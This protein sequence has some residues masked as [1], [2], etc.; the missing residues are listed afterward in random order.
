MQWQGF[1]RLAE[2]NVHIQSA[3]HSQSFDSLRNYRR[4]HK[5][6]V[7]SVFWCDYK[8]YDHAGFFEAN[9]N[10]VSWSFHFVVIIVHFVHENIFRF[11]Q[12]ASKW[13][14]VC[15]GTLGKQSPV[16]YHPK[17]WPILQYSLLRSF[18]SANVSTLWSSLKLPLVYTR[19]RQSCWAFGS[20]PS[21]R[22]AKPCFL[23]CW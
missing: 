18:M 16:S 3:L 4:F 1:F 17:K 21:G 8:F 9:D 2:E 19:I 15:S 6:W 20:L 10:D 12:F 22:R 23:S 7:F 5:E 11:A 13:S 14:V